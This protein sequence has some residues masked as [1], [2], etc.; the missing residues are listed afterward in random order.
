MLEWSPSAFL[1]VVRAL[2]EVHDLAALDA[3]IKYF[4]D[5]CA[6]IGAKTLLVEHEYIDRDYL[7]DYVEYYSRS[8]HPYKRFCTRVHFWTKAFTSD[9]FASWMST[10]PSQGTLEELQ[11]QYLGFVVLKPLPETVIGRTCLRP[12]FDLPDERK[13]LA[14]RRYEVGLFGIPLS[15]MTLAFQQ[16]DRV[17]SA[18]ATSALWSAFQATSTLFG[19]ALRTPAAITLA[20]N[21]SR[22]AV[23][24]VFPSQGLEPEQM[25]D[26]IRHAGLEPHCAKVVDGERLRN[27]VWAYLAANIPLVLIL[28]LFEVDAGDGSV[29]EL[30]DGTHAVA[31]TGYRVD[32]TAPTTRT[33]F[34]LRTSGSRISKVYVHDDGIGPF[35]RMTLSLSP[36]PNPTGGEPLERETF[37]TEWPCRAGREVR[38]TPVL[39]M[40]PAYPKIRITF[41]HIFDRLV[42][43]DSLIR[44]FLED[45]NLYERTEWQVCLSKVN[46]FKGRVRSASGVSPSHR[47]DTL[48]SPLP[49]YLWCAQ[50]L[51]DG[52]PGAEL[53]FDA[54][55][56]EQGDLL[57]STV[58]YQSEFCA[59]V[60]GYCEGLL[61]DAGMRTEVGS[62]LA[63]SIVEELAR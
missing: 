9:Q 12:Y 32:A 14:I 43:F 37:L 24:R 27:A 42:A 23:D 33:G 41:D 31:V 54:T 20:A 61:E 5:Y 58:D 26:A 55:D 16:Q 40:V 50:L 25:A 15:V 4:N 39:L 17:T 45:S 51:F 35:A 29:H 19:H 1:D 62:S 49:R 59:A 6:Y 22:R 10:G 63:R 56:L 11:S 2:P 18:C 30:V 34:A 28:E 36:A 57:V 21:A 8:F 44:D 60:R 3:H 7:D 13:F 53:V 48:T 52:Q 47:A 46:E 38:A